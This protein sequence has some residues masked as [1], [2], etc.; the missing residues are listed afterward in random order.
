MLPLPSIGAFF[1]RYLPHLIVLALVVGS[2]WWT[3]NWV[4]DRG[5]ASRNEEVRLLKVDRDKYKGLYEAAVQTQKNQEA[6]HK[7]ALSQLKTEQ[8]A[9]L[10]DLTLRLD[11]SLK[12]TR[13][14]EKLREQ[15]PLFVT[16]AA[17]ARC[18]VPRG[19]ALLHDHSARTGEALAAEGP[20]VPGG[21]RPDVDAASGVALSALTDTLLHNYGEC[22]QRGA[23]IDAWQTWYSKNLKAWKEAIERQRDFTVVAPPT[24]TPSQ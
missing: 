21:G 18:V 5:A 1:L 16:P 19:F 4:Y 14:L 10:K 7:E 15:V 17:D 22:H 11:H 2:V 9:V 20:A 3:Y 8:E 12:R 24:P 6:A 13:Q 23:V